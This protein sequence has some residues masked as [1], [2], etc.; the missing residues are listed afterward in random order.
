MALKWHPDKCKDENATE[1]FRSICESYTWLQGNY[2]A[3]DRKQKNEKINHDVFLHSM[4][5][6]MIF[7]S[8]KKGVTNIHEGLQTETWIDIA[9]LFGIDINV[10]QQYSLYLHQM[11]SMNLIYYVY[12][13]PKEKSKTFIERV[14]FLRTNEGCQK[15]TLIVKLISDDIVVIPPKNSSIELIQILDDL[16]VQLID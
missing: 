4:C 3:N 8:I 13:T 16:E 6:R 5:I 10:I 14:L 9:N 1:K 7:H 2:N 12:I 11:L 15:I